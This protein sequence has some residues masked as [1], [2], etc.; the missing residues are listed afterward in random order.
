MKERLTQASSYAGIAA[1][2]ASV[3][4]TLGVA[5]PY[6]AVITAIFGAIAFWL[7]K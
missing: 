2:T 7:K 5:Q 1:T 3:L 6:V 4:P